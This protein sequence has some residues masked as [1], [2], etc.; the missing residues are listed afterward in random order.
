VKVIRKTRGTAAQAT[1]ASFIQIIKNKV[2]NTSKT[3]I[4][5]S[6]IR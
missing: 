1:S 6:L 3:V 5:Q 2:I 4:I